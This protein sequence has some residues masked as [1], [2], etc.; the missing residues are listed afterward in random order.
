MLSACYN[1]TRA[2]YKFVHTYR[3][4]LYVYEYLVYS[5]AQKAAQTFLQEVSS[6]INRYR[7]DHSPLMALLAVELK[8]I[9]CKAR[10][11]I[12]KL[13]TNALYFST[14]R[15][16][17][18]F[19]IGWEKHIVPNEAPGFLFSWWSVFWDLYCAAPE[20]RDVLKHSPDARAFYDYGLANPGFVPNCPQPSTMPSPGIHYVQGRNAPPSMLQHQQYVSQPRPMYPPGI[21][22]PNDKIPGIVPM[23]EQHLEA[24]L[25]SP[26]A[27]TAA[28]FRPNSNIPSLPIA[29]APTVTL[30]HQPRPMGP[31]GALVANGN[32]V[33][34]LNSSSSTTSSSFSG[35]SPNGDFQSS[36]HQQFGRP[37]PF[38]Q[39]RS[40]P[41]K[42]SPCTP[43]GLLPSQ[44]Q[45][46]P[47]WGPGLSHSV[48][49]L[50]N[51]QSSSK[52]SPDIGTTTSS[53][54]FDPTLMEQLQSAPHPQPTPLPSSSGSGA[55][56]GD[57][58]AFFGQTD[59]LPVDETVVSGGQPQQQSQPSTSSQ[60]S[61]LL[62]PSPV[63]Q[64]PR[65]DAPRSKAASIEEALLLSA[66]E[67]ELLAGSDDATGIVEGPDQSING[68]PPGRVF[69]SDPMKVA[70]TP[71]MLFPNSDDLRTIPN[72]ADVMQDST[73]G[74]LLSSGSSV[75]KPFC[76]LKDI[77]ASAA[78][79]LQE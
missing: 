39:Q 20:R 66:P 34:S 30:R 45:Q 61:Q 2:H 68:P 43:N 1:L 19:K 79:F 70:E 18:S 58:F 33:G 40:L 51:P 75:Q 44:Q 53:M 64:A 69:D 42:M 38:Q 21:S 76:P 7:F 62:S 11:L 63:Q 57:G 23:G 31:R 50:G 72:L 47:Q 35:S 4:A 10:S 78:L 36:L 16:F 71:N 48:D 12:F 54:L 14:S 3:L 5:G 6:S 52:M 41:L 15:Y 25:S 60:I 17:F 24:F 49:F 29:S 22:R 46:Q 74:D 67:L 27:V 28:A 55:G 37:H 56:A 13:F 8:T 65:S 73:S 77:E 59:G 9:H 32:A 26:S